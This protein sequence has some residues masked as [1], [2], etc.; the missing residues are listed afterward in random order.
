MGM[1]LPIVRNILE[2]YGASIQF[3]EPTNEFATG[4]EITF[5]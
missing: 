5:R 1:G 2:E 4:I 3:V